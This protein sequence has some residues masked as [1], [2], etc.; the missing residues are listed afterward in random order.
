[1]M[2]DVPSAVALLDAIDDLGEA[3]D[4]AAGQG[5]VGQSNAVAALDF[6][7][8]D[9][10]R[11]LRGLNQNVATIVSGPR[12][13]FNIFARAAYDQVGPRLFDA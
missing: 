4:A 5:R 10:I 2:A 3:D 8:G 7:V 12:A 1:M 11:P 9:N 6:F 13:I